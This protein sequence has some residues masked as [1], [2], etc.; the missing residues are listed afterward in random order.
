MK[1]GVGTRIVFTL[2]LVVIIAMCVVVCLA[3]LNV[4]STAQIER[5][6]NGFIGTNYRYIYA[7]VAVVLAIVALCLMFFGRK[8]RTVEPTTVVL[9]ASADGSVH[10]S[11]DALKELCARYLNTVSGIIVQKITIHPVGDRNVRADIDIAVRPMTEVPVTSKEISDGIRTYVE[12]YSGI[13]VSDVRIRIQAIKDT[14]L[15]K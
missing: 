10:V 13:M 15:A 9:E 8:G 12:Q 11:V 5:L 2:F 3:A 1:M 7:G 14:Q 4:I 6:Y